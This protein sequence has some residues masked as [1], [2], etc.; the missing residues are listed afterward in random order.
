MK[1]VFMNLDE[2]LFVDLY[3]SYN[4]EY[5]QK[6]TLFSLLYITE[7]YITES[8]HSGSGLQSTVSLYF[9]LIKSLYG[10]DYIYWPATACYRD[11]IKV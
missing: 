10:W 2:A 5:D 3:I 6:T 9:T 11:V 4:I 8:W 7:V 1:V